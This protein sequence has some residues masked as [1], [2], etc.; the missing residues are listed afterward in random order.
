MKNDLVEKLKYLDS[1]STDKTYVVYKSITDES[2]YKIETYSLELDMVSSNLQ[3]SQLTNSPEE[4]I[5]SE[6]SNI[7]TNLA[8]VYENHREWLKDNPLTKNGLDLWLMF[9]NHA[10]CRL[11]PETFIDTVKYFC[12]NEKRTYW[13]IFLRQHNEEFKEFTYNHNFGDDWKDI[14]ADLIVLRDKLIPFLEIKRKESL[15][16]NQPNSVE[17]G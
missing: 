14:L 13:N 8:L 3:H 12:V 15:D 6:L 2:F 16:D 7:K 4:F 9:D 10:F 1:V 17:I 5:E 11:N